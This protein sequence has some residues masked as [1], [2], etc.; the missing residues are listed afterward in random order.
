[1]LQAFQSSRMDLFISLTHLNQKTPTGIIGPNDPEVYFITGVRCGD[2]K[3]RN[4]H[5][6]LNNQHT[7]VKSTQILFVQPYMEVVEEMRQLK[8]FFDFHTGF[9]PFIRNSSIPSLIW[10]GL[11]S[12]QQMV[13]YYSSGWSSGWNWR[14]PFFFRC[15]HSVIG[16]TVYEPGCRRDSI[17]P[18]A[19]SHCKRPAGD[20]AVMMRWSIGSQGTGINIEGL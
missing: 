8:N 2:A 3:W 9:K 6:T 17:V 1:M 20:R 10:S 12:S 15:C 11:K 4:I 13:R 18:P 7:Q 16:W 19:Y 14:N 5:S